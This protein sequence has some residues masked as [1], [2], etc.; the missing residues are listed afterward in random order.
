M[1][2]KISLI[3]A[4]PDPESFNHAIA[5]TGWQ[6]LERLGHQVCWHDLYAEG[7]I[8]VCPPTK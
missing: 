3:L 2:L 4:H 1:S 5:Q 8:P 6:T 7:S